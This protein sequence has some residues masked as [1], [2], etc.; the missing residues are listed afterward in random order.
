METDFRIRRTKIIATI[1]P[2]SDS[3]ATLKQMMEAGMSVARLNLSFGA[4]PDQVARVERIRQAAAE[5][6]R[7]IAIMA[8]TKGIEIRT[9]QVEGD[10]FDLENGENFNLYCEPEVGNT[11]GVSVTYRHL[12]REVEIGT[13][14]LLDDG[15]IE[16]IVTAIE[17]STIRCKVIHGGLLRSRKGVNLPHT[18]LSLSA[19]SPETEADVHQEMAFAVAN[20]IEYIAASFIQTAED[21]E[22]LRAVIRELGG[23]IPIIAKIENRAGI[24]NLEEIIEAA[25]GVMVAR[26]DL[27][28]ELPLADVPG[29]QKQIIRS[30]VSNGK[31]VITATRC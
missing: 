31:P 18:Q 4:G 21:I 14:I 16:L 1:G 6:G 10:Y 19:V 8:D 13:P 15:A 24:R 27:G 2:A 11:Q 26:G 25:D 9:G 23:E 17:G 29:M 5:S 22:R 12:Y 30:T 7:H 3:V 20:D 28:V